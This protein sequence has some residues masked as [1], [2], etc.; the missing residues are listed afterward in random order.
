MTTIGV[1]LGGTKILAAVVKDGRAHKHIKQVTPTAGPAAVVDA[2]VHAVHELG[3]AD[4][5]GLGTPGVV[6]HHTGAVS[7]APNLVAWTDT[8]P[9]R[10]LLKQA[11]PDTKIRIDNDVNVGV[12]GE[13]TAGAARDSRT[14]S[15]CSRAPASAEG[16]SSTATYVEV[17]VG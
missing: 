5:I 2:I 15:A 1:D 3:G 16:S 8:V 13:Q 17:L 12:L 9:L 11:L 6:D 4:R 14:C 10:D 7:N